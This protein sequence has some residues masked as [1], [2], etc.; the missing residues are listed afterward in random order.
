MTQPGRKMGHVTILSDNRID[1]V[2]KAHKIKHALKVF[3]EK[4]VQ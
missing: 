2:H 3:S 1:L 4:N